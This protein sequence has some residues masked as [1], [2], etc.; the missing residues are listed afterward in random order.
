MKA[1]IA[2]L[3]ISLENLETN[4]P[5]RRAEGDVEQADAWAVN[6]SEIRQALAVLKAAD[7]GPIWPEPNGELDEQNAKRDA[8][9]S[10]VNFMKIYTIATETH[11]CYGH[12]DFGTEQRIVRTGSY[13]SG[14][15][16]PAFTTR[17]AATEWLK[18]NGKTFYLKTA[19]VELELLGAN[20]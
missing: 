18:A 6:A 8:T 4:I 9:C 14:G 17:E 1:A 2:Q 3:E 12:G 19:I 7:D 20:A 10:A 16:P 5:I 11:E 13:G 15:F